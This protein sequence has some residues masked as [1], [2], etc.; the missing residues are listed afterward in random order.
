ML[1][2]SP[3]LFWPQGKEIVGA[4]LKSNGTVNRPH[5]GLSSKNS[6]LYISYK[7]MG[8]GG[9]VIVGQ[10]ITSIFSKTLFKRPRQVERTLLALA[11]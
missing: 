2:G 4:P 3:S 11:Y 5:W 7:V 6:A 9:V 10:L 8:K 1:R